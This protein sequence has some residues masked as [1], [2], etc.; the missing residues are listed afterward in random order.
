MAPASVIAEW[1]TKPEEERK[2]AETKMQA[3]WK[4]WMSEHAAVF[5]DMGGGVGKTKRVT[6]EGVIDSKNDIMLYAIVQAESHDEAAHL[7]VG[8]PH[9]GVPEASI[10]VMAINA[11][12]N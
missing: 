10:E 5:A 9:F 1:M 4:Q 8:H 3:E 11:M 12:P 2:A 6:K 7:F